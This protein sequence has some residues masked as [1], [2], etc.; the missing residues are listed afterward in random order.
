MKK[1]TKED[2][3]EIKDGCGF[4]ALILLALLAMGILVQFISWP[5]TP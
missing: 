2:L 4:I 5:G 1:E 3:K